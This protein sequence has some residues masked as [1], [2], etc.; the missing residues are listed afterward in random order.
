MTEPA[1]TLLWAV[2]SYCASH[3]C[4][5]CYFG[6]SDGQPEAAAPGV[7]SHLSPDDLTAAEVVAFASTLGRSAVGRVF[8]AG[9]EPL[10][11]RPMTRLIEVLRAQGL[12]VVVCTSGV[13]LARPQVS[14]AL[15][16]LGVD[17][18]SV[19]LDSADPAHH[20]A[21]RPPKQPGDGWDR[22]IAGVRALLTA[23]AATPGRASASTA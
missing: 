10:L 7:L 18:V 11:W 22:V 15:V 5:Y 1:L 21:W 2:R 19:S 3:G 6:D 23:R 17:A 16:R 20:D 14:S 8:L 4:R 13:A 12:E 9:G